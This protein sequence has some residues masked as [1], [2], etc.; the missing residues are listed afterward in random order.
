[1]DI[2]AF[3]DDTFDAIEW[4]NKT[5]ANA[6]DKHVNKELFLS[7]LVS[8]MQLYVQ[9]LNSALEDTSQQVLSAIPK[10][11]KDAQNL[12][13][14]AISLKAQMSDVQSNIDQV[15][16]NTGASMQ[17]LEHLDDLKSKLEF[18]KQGILE[19]DGWGRLT[20]ELDELIEHSK[21]ADACT[22]LQ[23]LQKSLQAQ[24]GLPHQSER[25]DQV[26]DFKN[27]LE[28]LASPGVV[29][30]FQTGDIE[31]SKKFVE[32]FTVMER[33]PQ[34][35]QYYRTVQKKILQQYWTE[36]VD[37]SQNSG[38]VNC[39]R[40]FYDHLAENWQKESKWCSSVFGQNGYHESGLVIIDSLVSLQP[41][42]D[43][44][45]TNAI[46]QSNDKLAVLA[47]ASTANIYFGGLVKRCI[48]SSPTA[49]PDQ[50][51]K[52]LIFVIYDF[53]D[54][55]ITQ[56]ASAEQNHLLGQLEEFQLIH[57]TCADSVRAL[58]NTNSK[59]FVLC[60]TAMN[61]CEDITQSCG[62]VSLVTSLNYILKI[63]LDKYKKA[64]QQLHA[65][66][67]S[68][69]NWSLLQTCIS[70]LQ[71][72]GDFTSQLTEFGN[73]IADRLVQLESVHLVSDKALHFGYKIK[74][75]RELNEFRKLIGS[76]RLKNEKHSD[77]DSPGATFTVFAPTFE[78]LKPICEYIHDTTLASIFSPIEKY[79]TSNVEPPE[80]E[81]SFDQN[82]PDYSFAPQEF[83]TQVGQYLLTLPQHLEPLLLSPS[84][85]L[86]TALELCD[87]KYSQN[88]PSTDV[89][90]S[91]L[92][93]EC[94]AMYEDQIT[95][96]CQL[97]ATASK[98][99]ATDIEYLGNVL[100]ELGLPL[101][102]RLRQTVTLL[103]APPETYLSSSSGCDP[104]LVSS[105]RQM[106]NII[107]G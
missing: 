28:A 107:S 1:M 80:L 36:C 13:N 69:Q 32:M 45:I 92:V 106:R 18:A 102:N 20:T 15:Q 8:K 4:I 41:G 85:Y 89:L 65:S 5:Y 77:E 90:L 58:G 23:A 101:S 87:T 39:L 7:N 93:D 24:V 43:M 84:T 99:I 66:R 27:R 60:T 14:A 12:Q 67:N 56:Y 78:A 104:K 105:I 3:S 94:C 33:L 95:Q 62:L 40:T 25:E 73:K 38:S 2:E 82:L 64:Q 55:F 29:Q 30:S 100:E 48:A 57:S 42:R 49:F 37:S 59:L 63:F 44:I 72:I 61:R 83:I 16:R 98:Q 76:I 81:N 10:I 19:S 70:L 71:N 46:K 9:Q 21:L 6:S 97:S 91:L 75:K 88:I 11:M 26:E 68:E 54:S 96:I 34:L 35:T 103:R 53:F 74:E 79:L 47:E 52:S 86:K 17:N 22:K 50:T 51:V 31:S